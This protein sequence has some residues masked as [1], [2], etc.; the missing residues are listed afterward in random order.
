VSAA[1]CSRCATPLEAGDLRCATC[2]Q[3]APVRDD[4]PPEATARI[5]RCESCGAA[6]AFSAE[7][8]GTR[9][10]FCGSVTRL[11]EPHDPIEAAELYLPFKTSPEAAHAAVR[12]WLGTLGFFRP[13]DLARAATIDN[14]KPLFFAAWVFDA[15]ALVSWAADSDQGSRRSDWAPHAGQ[16][17]MRFDAILVSAS[18]GL[19]ADEASRLA[20][21]FDL[22]TSG[23]SPQGPEGATVE[24]FDVQRSAART[25]IARALEAT[26]VQRVSQGEV[27]GRRVRNC[28]VGVVLHGLVSKRY[29]LPAYVLAY[30][31]DGKVYRAIVHGQTP[32]LT[33]GDAPLSW[34]KIIGIVLGVLALVAVI[35]A[36]A[37]GR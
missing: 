31:Y 32:Q 12:G 36:I 35:V 19:Q 37:A 15:D 14:I 27:P 23:K 33:F 11:E 10:V 30:R 2:A 20:P 16:T 34:R 13:S 4:V 22:R 8:Q 28:H 26:A 29:A 24:R 6:V 21:G 7:H 25:I 1:A 3:P 18:R 5:L 9:C 17:R